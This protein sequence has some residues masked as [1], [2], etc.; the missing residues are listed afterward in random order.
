[1][2]T[3]IMFIYCL[4]TKKQTNKQTNKQTIKDKK[5]PE[6][7]HENRVQP[8][9]NWNIVESGVKHHNPN[10]NP[11]PR[12]QSQNIVLAITIYDD[13]HQTNHSR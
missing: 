4:W 7:I 6:V 9:Y 5:K 12:Y 1:M 3:R 10:D 13:R 11:P 2:V 8:R